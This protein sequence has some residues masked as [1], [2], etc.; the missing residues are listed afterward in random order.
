[1]DGLAEPFIGHARAQG[2]D[3]VGW[4]PNRFSISI[5]AILLPPREM[6]SLMRPTISTRR[7]ART[8][9]RS[10]GSE[11]TV[12][13]RCRR[14][15][16]LIEIAEHAEWRA[17]LQLAGATGVQHCAVLRRDPEGDLLG[18]EANRADAVRHVRRG[19]AEIA[20]PRLGEPVEIEHAG[21]RPGFPDRLGQRRPKRLAAGEDHAQCRRRG[22]GAGNQHP[23]HGGDGRQHG[24]AA[25]KL[26]AHPSGEKRGTRMMRAPPAVP[27]GRP[28]CRR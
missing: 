25:R 24:G 8:R 26:L 23:K 12:T 2:A 15:A 16:L 14:E 19:Q 5:G 28:R 18:R 3:H 27:A 21:A 7:S 11:K 22:R 17:D 9:T 20:R 1:M 6:I 10:T 13:E 4:L